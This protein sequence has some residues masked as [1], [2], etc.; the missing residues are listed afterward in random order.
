[1][2]ATGQGSAGLLDVDWETLYPNAP[3]R[4]KAQRNAWSMSGLGQMFGAP[5]P[6]A[7]GGGG[8]G[9]KPPGG[10]RT[11]PA[12]PP[13]PAGPTWGGIGTNVAQTGLRAMGPAGGVAANALGTGMS[14]GFGAGLMG[15]VGGL[16]ALGVGKL[17][18]GIS[19]RVETAE[20][21]AVAYDRL[22]RV[23]GDV[24]VS[25]DGLKSVVTSSGDN[26][27]ITYQEA[28]RL[29]EQF[30]RLGNLQSDQ[31]G[32]LGGEL[33]VGVGMSRSF[34][35]DPSAGVGVMGQMRGLG[36]TSSTQESRRFAM[37]IGETIGK[38]SAFAK[39]G[40]VMEAVASYAANQTRSDMGVANVGGYAGMFSGMV[41]SG[42]AG[43][44]PANASALLARVNATLTGGGAKGEASQFFTGMVG[45]RMGL[46]PMQTQLLREGGAFATNR[47]TFGKDSIA[48]R[49]GVSGPGGDKTFLS[50]TLD[51]LRE[52][53]DMSTEEGRWKA[54]QAGGNHLGVS[55]RQA[56]GLLSVKPNEMGEMEKYGDLTKLSESGIG[57]VSKALYGT[58]GDRQ[59]MADSLLSRTG[60]DKLASDDAKAITDARGNDSQLRDVLA[61]MAAKYGQE[62]TT[63]S[64]IRDSK[65]LLDNIK[66]ALADKLVPLAQDMRA[67][68][69]W[70]A[71][72]RKQS[73]AEVLTDIANKE[74][75]TRASGIK[76]EH[77]NQRKNLQDEYNKRL[78]A[79]APNP[80]PG[81]M[82]GQKWWQDA[83]A[84]IQNG[85]ITPEER[86]AFDE[87]VKA[88]QEA[89]LK[90]MTN[91]NVAAEKRRL[92]EEMRGKM[93]GID[94]AEGTAIT[95]ESERYKK[96]LKA[97]ADSEAAR[98][99]IEDAD[100]K[101]VN[102]SSPVAGAASK[103]ARSF[104][105]GKGGNSKYDA[106][107]A[108]YGK[109]YGVDPALL[110]AIAQKE[111][112][113]D[114]SA[115]SPKNE[116][117]SQDFGLM[118]HN[119]K[120]LAERGLKDDWDIPERSIEESAK[121][122][123]RN[124]KKAGSVRGGVKLY[125]GTG[126]KAERYA[127]SIMSAVGG[128]SVQGT[129]MP[130]DEAA[131]QRRA[132][133]GAGQAASGANGEVHVKL[134]VS[135]EAS[136]LLRTPQAPV[137]TSFGPAGAPMVA[138]N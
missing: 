51:L 120:Y 16:A 57:N 3:T 72:D 36:V 79:V 49:Y 78:E 61:K 9:Q 135:P 126:P 84:K 2:K 80:S 137:Y 89:R 73:Q 37:L 68:I 124:I 88:T 18:S 27:K 46:D 94:K 53:F 26:L 7:G 85:T 117:G 45:Q 65:A 122:L 75:G 86:K 59:S 42:I 60:S 64:A 101:A 69:L 8:G 14:A 138:R 113:M 34:G 104:A 43:M 50:S 6:P 31:Y 55:M 48:A 130:A 90:G 115:I 118:Q 62:E 54:A 121:L 107:F 128:V 40:E 106:L 23:L 100:P 67:G 103:S 108:K 38:S 98:L 17:I 91:P 97:I 30:A 63:G 58:A 66:T 96:Q 95:G 44:D 116:N 87:R 47:S 127:D 133:S 5:M 99:A 11:P 22:K 119:S 32:T 102:S 15:L 13:P 35:L 24:S 93:T 41:G 105:T 111:S 4:A 82:M 20:N 39:A 110:K 77:E 33:G 70:L 92:G 125:N 112:S 81:M 109:E 56:M 129:P 1:M 25:F 74:H 136:R 132:T 134:D 114:P 52:Q 123:A 12:P 19:E 28:G 71:G 83:T 21:N 76:A 131:A 10:N 29:G